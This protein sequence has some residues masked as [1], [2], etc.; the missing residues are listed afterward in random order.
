MGK[1]RKLNEEGVTMLK[2]TRALALV[3]AALLF[4][5]AA[6]AQEL[7]KFPVSASS[8]VLGYA[9]LW[10]AAKR[11]IFA[12]HGLEAQVVLMR[13]GDKAVQALVGGSVYAAVSTPDVT[14]AAVEQG[15]DLA[16]IGGMSNKST[17]LV[18][19]GK[20]H[21]TYEDLRGAT[22]GSSGLASGVAFLLKRVLKEK[23]LEYPRDYKLINVGGSPL[24]L[25][26]LASGQIG[27]ALLSIPTSYAAEEMGFNVI[28]MAV[29]VV[30]NYALSSVSTRRS[31]AEKNRPL[32][33][34]FMKAMAVA[35]RWVHENKEA[36][37]KL[38]A[39]EVALKPEHARK[40]WEYYVNNKV[41]DPDGRVNPEGI[42]TVA[43]IYAEQTQLK[44]P[45]PEPDKYVDQSYM[46]E[47]LKE[48]G[49]K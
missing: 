34:R 37:I 27:A 24:A 8:K 46:N 41:W 30:P 44:G 48:L 15:L 38:L 1:S 47:A 7:I 6:F 45:V 12:Q 9:P 31:W 29:D 26:A 42:R 21:K 2:Q 18:I 35:M 32:M 28:G 36:A 4:S 5:S 40:G 16:I 10:I 14:V 20:G 17:H 49:R 39:T 25:Q 13:G 23:G 22:I 11:G 3:V 33:V 43:Q 19:G